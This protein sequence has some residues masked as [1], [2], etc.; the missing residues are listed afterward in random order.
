MPSKLYEHIRNIEKAN[1]RLLKNA[2]DIAE[3]ELNKASEEILKE[4]KRMYDV[5]IDQYYKYKTTSYYRHDVGIGTGTGMNLYRA[6]DFGFDTTTIDE[7][8]DRGIIVNLKNVKIKYNPNSMAKYRKFPRAR[9]LDMIIN[10]IRGVPGYTDTYWEGEYN[11][12]YFSYKG[13][14][15]N[16]FDEFLKNESRIEW[17]IVRNKASKQVAQRSNEYAKTIERNVKNIINE[18][19]NQ[20]KE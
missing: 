15:K 12:K 17:E 8:Q 2:N 18:M 14:M 4:A 3:K 11:G 19:T 6:Q 7:Y 16:A 9:V 5:F 10:G 20:I 1:N 13:I